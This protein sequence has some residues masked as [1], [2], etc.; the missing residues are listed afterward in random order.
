MWHDRTVQGQYFGEVKVALLNSRPI[1]FCHRKV[2]ERR[3]QGRRQRDLRYQ[4]VGFR[5]SADGKSAELIECLIPNPQQTERRVTRDL[6]PSICRI[7]AIRRYHAIGGRDTVGNVDAVGSDRI[8]LIGI[9]R[10]NIQIDSICSNLHP[11]G[12]QVPIRC[13]I[14]NEPEGIGIGCQ[15]QGVIGKIK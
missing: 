13:E 1:K 11:M 15:Y 14:E 9:R 10:P 3:V 8:E 5:L 7:G 12:I 6:L 2:V 4:D